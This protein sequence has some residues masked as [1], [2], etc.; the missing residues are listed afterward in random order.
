MTDVAIIGAG[1]AGL[2]AAIYARRA[3]LSAVVFEGLCYGGQIINTPDIDN[4]PGIKNIS[5]FDFATG[6][7]E[8][9]T[10]FGAQVRFEAVVRIEGDYKS[11]FLVKTEHSEELARTVILATGSKNRHM[12]LPKEEEF[13]GKGISYC[14]TCDGNFYKGKT[15]AVI[16]G[17]N[18][19]L[20]DAI[21]LSDLCEKVYL[22]HRREEFRG[23]ENLVQ[24]VKGNEKTELVTPYTVDAILGEDRLTGVTLKNVKTSEIKV[25]NLDGVFVAIGQV[26]AAKPFADFVKQNDGYIVAG[27]DTKTNIPGVFAAGD[28]RTKKVRQLATAASD[29]AVAAL[30]AHEFIKLGGN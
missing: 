29:G 12:E 11:G 21:Y 4:Y 24:I 10:G 19:A 15:V 30:A 9:A 5:G 3:G 17:G 27:E 2:T 26:P 25:I 1:P 16:G 28:G 22:I 7:F 6:L 18:T 13:I 20:E 8:Q 14:A 23:E